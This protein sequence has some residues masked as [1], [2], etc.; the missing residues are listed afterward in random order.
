MLYGTILKKH[1]LNIKYFSLFFPEISFLFLCF[2]LKLWFYL[3]KFCF[4]RIYQRI[5]KKLFCV[6]SPCTKQSCNAARVLNFREMLFLNFRDIWF[7]VFGIFKISRYS[8]QNFDLKNNILQVSRKKKRK[9]ID[10]VRYNYKQKNALWVCKCS[11]PKIRNIL[12]SISRGFLTQNL[13][14]LTQK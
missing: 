11:P 9:K 5:T 10:D 14:F 13:H 3:T 2:C 4:F 12:F 7:V 8:I 1:A 6:E